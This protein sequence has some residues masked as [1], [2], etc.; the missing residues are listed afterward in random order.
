MVKEKVYAL[1]HFLTRH[2]EMHQKT[3]VLIITSWVTLEINW[4]VL[5]LGHLYEHF[6]SISVL[7]DEL[8]VTSLRIN[9]FF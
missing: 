7:P 2:L 5:R 9:Q 1:I 6:S 3:L 4:V 8:E